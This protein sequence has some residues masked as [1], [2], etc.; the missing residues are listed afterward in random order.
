MRCDPAFRF[1]SKSL[2]D[3]DKKGSLADSAEDIKMFDSPDRNTEDFEK[4]LKKTMECI[5]QVHTTYIFIF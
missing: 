5:A 2:G 3:S 1:N 4:S